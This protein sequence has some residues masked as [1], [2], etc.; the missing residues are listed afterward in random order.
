MHSRSTIIILLLLEN[1]ACLPVIKWT[2]YPCDHNMPTVHDSALLVEGESLHLSCSVCE[3]CEPNIQ[4]CKKDFN[5]PRWIKSLQ[6]RVKQKDSGELYAT[7]ASSIRDRFFFSFTLFSYSKTA[8]LESKSN[9]F[10]FK[11]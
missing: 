2:T 9:P 6:T 4:E 1:L 8:F 5:L 11:F 7:D 10:K 3:R